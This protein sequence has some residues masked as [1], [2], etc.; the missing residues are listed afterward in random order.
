ML[1]DLIAVDGRAARAG[2]AWEHAH[3]IEE[4][5]GD[6]LTRLAANTRRIACRTPVLSRRVSRRN[7]VYLDQAAT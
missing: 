3:D 5:F 1:S 4:F 7:I 6:L 2:Y